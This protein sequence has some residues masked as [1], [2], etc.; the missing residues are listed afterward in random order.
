MATID[1][2]ERNKSRS[3]T[4]VA[5]FNF[6]VEIYPTGG[7]EGELPKLSLPV[8][9]V[10]GLS[11]GRTTSIRHRINS[12][13]SAVTTPYPGISTPDP[14][15]LEG[16][17]LFDMEDLIAL[18]MWRKEVKGQKVVNPGG[19]IAGYFRNIK[20]TP[21]SA[22]PDGDTNPILAG[23]FKLKNAWAARLSISDFDINSPA[24]CNWSLEIE[25][26]DMETSPQ[27]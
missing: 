13:S 8:D 15:T 24:I 22:N 10:R 16:S 12:T 4:G 26:E 7:A 27:K 20:V 1:P 25:Y 14:V 19:L 17:F 6:L 21:V 5:N 11:D 9:A 23:S 2:A 3:T 18:Q